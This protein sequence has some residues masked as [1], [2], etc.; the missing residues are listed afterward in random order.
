MAL[1]FVFVLNVFHFIYFKR[2]FPSVLEL[3]NSC[4]IEQ[5]SPLCASLRCIEELLLLDDLLL[6]L[7]QY[8]GAAAIVFRI[9][10]PVLFVFGFQ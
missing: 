3:S 5:V 8:F 1:Y 9:P 10:I 7:P 4:A 2:E 6:C